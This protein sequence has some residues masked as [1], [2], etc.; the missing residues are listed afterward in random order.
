MADELPVVEA[1]LAYGSPG[2]HRQRLA[3]QEDGACVYPIAWLGDRPVG[4]VLVRWIGTD[5]ASVRA[6]LTDCPDVQDLFV[7]P[8]ARSHGYG[9]QLLEAAILLVRNSGYQRIGLSVGI[10]NTRAQALYQRHGFEDLGIAPFTISGDWGSETCRYLV[11]P[12]DH[13][14]DR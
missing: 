8:D 12:L 1:H 5:T 14:P 4:H 13:P 7:A 2:K 11:K 3:A 9:T 6:R 10:D